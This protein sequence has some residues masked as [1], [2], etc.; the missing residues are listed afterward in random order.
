MMKRS[1]ILFYGTG[2][3]LLIVAL[4]AIS[5]GIGLILEP[6]GSNIG[7]SVELLNKSPFQNFLIPGIVLLTVNGIGSLVGSL[8]SFKRHQLTSIATISL[9]VILIIWI[10]AQVYWLGL[11]S[12]LQPLFFAIGLLEIFLGGIFL[13]N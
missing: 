6:D 8:L 9:G 13:I 3:L 2:V 11:I 4:G 1:K 10:G 7:M 12:I 5:A